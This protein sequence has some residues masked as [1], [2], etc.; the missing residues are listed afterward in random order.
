[1]L[2]RNSFYGWIFVGISRTELKGLTAI[3]QI[4]DAS[5]HRRQYGVE[6]RD[7]EETTAEQS[8]PEA[9]KQP[10]LIIRPLELQYSEDFAVDGS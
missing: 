7:S 2:M 8:L 3:C 5:D 1:M 6:L 9:D 4:P 10:Y